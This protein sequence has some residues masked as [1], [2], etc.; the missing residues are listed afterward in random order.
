MLATRMRG[1]NRLHHLKMQAIY[2][3]GHILFA[4]IKDRSNQKKSKATYLY[5]LVYQK[6]LSSLLM[7][8]S[9]KM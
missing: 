4:L 6:S 2:I 8:M 1:W 7:A 5:L 9:R 3:F